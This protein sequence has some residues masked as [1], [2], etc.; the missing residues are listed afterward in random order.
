MYRHSCLD[1]AFILGRMSDDDTL[2]ARFT[3]SVWYSFVGGLKRLIPCSQT[4]TPE[5]IKLV[6]ALKN[7]QE[8]ALSASVPISSNEG[9]EDAATSS[10]LFGLLDY[11]I[12]SC[13]YHFAPFERENRIILL[14]EVRQSWLRFM[15]FL[16][17]LEILRQKNSESISR[18]SKIDSIRRQK[19]LEGSFRKVFLTRDPD[20]SRDEIIDVLEYFGIDCSRDMR[21]VEEEIRLLVSNTGSKIAKEKPE[22][23]NKPWSIKLDK[24]NIR[25]IF[26]SQVFR[27]D[28]AQPTISLA[29]FA[30]I[31]IESMKRKTGNESISGKG[32]EFSYINQRIEDE[33]QEL[34]KRAWDDWKD[35]NPRG[36]GNKLANVG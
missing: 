16:Y 36:S 28:V 4:T 15:A 32:D 7:L 30:E 3:E 14:R 17:Q 33:K 9:I 1:L 19:L 13:L 2:L 18:E 22:P 12:G 6:E 27:P 34:K 10:L 23:P 5:V 25:Q 31:E 26:A 20:D 8:D 24:T 11:A 35:E 29:E 21:F